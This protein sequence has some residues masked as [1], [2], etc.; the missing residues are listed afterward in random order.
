MDGH[1]ALGLG[2]VQ[3]LG[4]EGQAEDYGGCLCGDVGETADAGKGALTAMGI[5]IALGIY[6]QCPHKADI[7]ATGVVEGVESTPV[8]VVDGLIVSERGDVTI[9]TVTGNDVTVHN[10]NLSAG[11]Y[12]VRVGTDVQKVM[13]R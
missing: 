8:T 6:L 13:I 11:V 3:S 4:V 5:D 9:Y 7:E 2:N 1:N 12:L 10:G